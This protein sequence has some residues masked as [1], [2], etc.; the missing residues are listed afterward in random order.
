[1][2][3]QEDEDDNDDDD[4]DVVIGRSRPNLRELGKQS[5]KTHGGKNCSKNN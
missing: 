2:D 5:G 3:A 4:D 1:M